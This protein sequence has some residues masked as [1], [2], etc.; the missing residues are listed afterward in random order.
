MKRIPRLLALVGTA[1]AVGFSCSC[2]SLNSSGNSKTSNS[3]YTSAVTEHNVTQ[4]IESSD[5][6]EFTGYAVVLSSAPVSV[7]GDLRDILYHDTIVS[8]VGDDV[9]AGVY[10]IKYH[11][12]RLA[13]INKNLVRL[14]PTDSVSL[15]SQ[16]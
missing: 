14:L 6:K 2:S 11:D 9:S 1:V 7:D 13:R 8:I 5:I 16:R 3:I 4:T 12:N 10:I 15:K